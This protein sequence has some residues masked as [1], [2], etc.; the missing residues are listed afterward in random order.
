[1]QPSN[2]NSDLAR[3]EELIRDLVGGD[4][5]QK[6]LIREHLEAARFYLHGAMLAEYLFNLELA[7]GLVSEL[8]DKDLQHRIREFV[9]SQRSTVT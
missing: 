5:T 4:D 2:E 8:G 1:M 3:L 7:E 9:R 6:G